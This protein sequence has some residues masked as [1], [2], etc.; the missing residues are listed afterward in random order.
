MILLDTDMLSG[1][2][3]PQPEAAVVAWL[4]RQPRI[5]V[6]ITAITVLEIRFGIALMPPGSR[7]TRLEGAF[8][9]AIEKIEGRIVSFDAPAAEEAANLM[10]ERRRQGRPIE[11]RD[12]MIAGVA[13]AQRATLA[14]RNIRHFA[15]LP[16]AVVDPWVA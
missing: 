5:S 8:D 3:R 4:D 15:D 14:T 11:L 13:I 1:L 6:W 2:M 12:T 16:V 7:R 9:R 10:A